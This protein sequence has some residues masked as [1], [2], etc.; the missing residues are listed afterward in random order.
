GYQCRWDARQGVAELHRL[1]ERIEFDQATHEFRAYTRLKQLK[2]LSRTDQIDE[3]FF[4]T[5]S[6]RSAPS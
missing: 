4:W 2:Y 6:P 3:R 5:S 1:F